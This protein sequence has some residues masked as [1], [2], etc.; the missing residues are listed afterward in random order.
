MA[1]TVEKRGPVQ[2][3]AAIV[4]GGTNTQL[5]AGLTYYHPLGSKSYTERIVGRV[6]IKAGKDNAGIIT[7]S[8]VDPQ[9]T[10][11]YFLQAGEEKEWIAYNPGE[12]YVLGQFWVYGTGTDE[13]WWNYTLR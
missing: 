8:F 7:V 2:Y 10:T 13:A 11:K 1:D 6:S 4:P 3:Q 9:G 5:G 12:R